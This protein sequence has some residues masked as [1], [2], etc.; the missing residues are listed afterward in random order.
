MKQI[1]M[2]EST[3][4]GS[5]ILFANAPGSVTS[6]RMGMV[7]AFFVV[8]TPVRKNSLSD[9]HVGLPGRCHIQFRSDRLP[10]N[11]GAVLKR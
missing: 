4:S 2:Q 7:L 3:Q 10:Q 9:H 11:D 1:I 8:R 6:A 5:N